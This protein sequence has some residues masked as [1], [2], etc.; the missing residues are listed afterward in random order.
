MAPDDLKTFFIHGRGATW[1][2]RAG[3]SWARTDHEKWFYDLLDGPTRNQAQYLALVSVLRY[4][5]PSS[6]VL[7]LTDSQLVVDQFCGRC[8]V[9]EAE[10]RRLAREARTLMA[11][12]HLDVEVR[13]ADKQEENPAREYLSQMLELDLGGLLD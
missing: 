4:V 10:L 13:Q 5:V 11:D 6:N 8:R 7:I 1:N 3:Y 2:M 12:K 9:R